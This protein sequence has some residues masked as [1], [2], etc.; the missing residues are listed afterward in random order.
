[1]YVIKKLYHYFNY[2]SDKIVL[3]DKEEFMEKTNKQM[4]KDMAELHDINNV[5]N[6]SYVC[7]RIK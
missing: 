6:D 3:I 1:M 2:M 4:M 7:G 5:T